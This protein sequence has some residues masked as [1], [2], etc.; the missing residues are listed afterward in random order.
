MQRF[1]AHLRYSSNTEFYEFFAPAGGH[2]KE[3]KR[4]MNG[5]ETKGDCTE[6]GVSG[7]QSTAK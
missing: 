2:L 4:Q 5:N 7:N 3:E 6:K 1:N